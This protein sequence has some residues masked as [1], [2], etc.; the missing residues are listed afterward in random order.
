MA[1]VTMRDTGGGVS[2]GGWGCV[3]GRWRSLW[4]IFEV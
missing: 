2:A 3:G 4:L 1:A